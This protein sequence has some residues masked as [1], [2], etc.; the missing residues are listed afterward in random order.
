MKATN[1]LYDGIAELMKNLNESVDDTKRYK[2]EVGQLANNLT[3][4]NTV[5][6]NMLNAMKG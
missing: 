4:L 2:T 1:K 6:G 5:Y 3:S